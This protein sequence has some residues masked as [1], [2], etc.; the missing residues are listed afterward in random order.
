MSPKALR[1]SPKNETRL[2]EINP[3]HSNVAIPRRLSWDQVTQNPLWTFENE[4][5]PVREAPNSRLKEITELADGSVQVQFA[6]SSLLSRYSFTSSRPEPSKLSNKP[7]NNPLRNSK[8]L[9]SPQTF[10]KL[11]IRK[12]KMILPVMVQN[13]LLFQI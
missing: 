9:I 11:I 1:S 8:V 6:S 3:L 13:P 5:P 10:L 7:R 12:K 4:L 2:I